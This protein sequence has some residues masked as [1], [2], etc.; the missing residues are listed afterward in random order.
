M[1]MMPEVEQAAEPSSLWG[2][3]HP[4]LPPPAGKKP[5]PRKVAARL[6]K[7]PRISGYD[8]AI[9]EP[10]DAALDTVDA[11]KGK[12]P[13]LDVEQSEEPPEPLVF[14][15]EQLGD[16]FTVTFIGKRR[17]GKT[18]AMRYFLNYMKDRFPR[19]YVFTATKINGFWQ[20]YIPRRFI[21]DAYYPGVLEAILVAQ[22]QLIEWYNGATDE[23]K[24]HVDPRLLIILDDVIAQDLH[25]DE[26]LK[27]VFFNGRHI[28]AC[29]MITAQYA[30]GLP[31]GLRENTD[32]AVLFRLHSLAQREAASENFLGHWPK[33]NAMRYLDR[34]VWTDYATQQ[35]QCLVV[36]NSGRSPIEHSLY[37]CQ[38]KEPADEGHWFLGSPEFWGPDTPKAHQPRP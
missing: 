19:V 27:W 36:D 21:F 29:L 33:R 22:R 11:Q 25:H 15:L 38:P 1:Q 13:L 30:K 4:R 18:F 28:K 35:R 7:D 32:L 23:E 12:R 3:G 20:K 2:V 31:P 5:D 10:L 14:N 24:T 9:E 37:I 16:D 17:E 34:H 26:V 8:D 6:K